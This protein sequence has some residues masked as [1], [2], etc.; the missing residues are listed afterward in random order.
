MPFHPNLKVLRQ[1]RVYVHVPDGG[2]GYRYQPRGATGEGG[3]RV[4]PFRSPGW[5]VR[6][7]VHVSPPEKLV[8]VRSPTARVGAAAAV[9]AVSSSARAAEEE[10]SG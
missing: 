10:E 1:V 9:V 6:A 7:V 2:V 5:P 4:V 8:V 3:G